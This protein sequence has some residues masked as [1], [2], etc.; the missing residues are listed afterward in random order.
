[1]TKAKITT[2]VVQADFKGK[3]M[4]RIEKFIGTEADKYPV[5]NFGIKKAKIL[6]DH[7]EELKTFVKENDK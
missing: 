6:L 5:H 1:M 4:F 2:K 7:I 3:E